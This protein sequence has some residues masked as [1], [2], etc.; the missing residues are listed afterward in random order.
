MKDNK[1]VL[2]ELE[3]ELEPLLIKMDRLDNF[4]MSPD[5]LKLDHRMCYLLNRQYEAMESYADILM[6]R[7][8]HIKRSLREEK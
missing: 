7:I 3:D 2:K 4:R 8:E 6:L 1:I 5:I